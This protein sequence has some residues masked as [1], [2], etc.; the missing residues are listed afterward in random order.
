MGETILVM[1]KIMPYQKLEEEIKNQAAFACSLRYEDISEKVRMRARYVLL[2][3]VGCILKGL[4]GQT[5]S[6]SFDDA[7]M[8]TSAAMLSTELYEGNRF[9]CGHPACHIVPMM[10]EYLRRHD[11]SERKVL[12]AFVAAYEIAARWGSAV[13]FERTIL[14]HGTVM[15]AGAAV[16][17]ALLE[18]DDESTVTQSILLANSL[19]MLSVW[20]TVYDGSR[21]HDAYPGLAALNGIRAVKMARQG[22]YST[23]RIIL[24]VYENKMRA[25]AC[26]DNLDKG[27]LSEDAGNGKTDYLLLK[28]YFKLFTGCR[29]IH[30]FADVVQEE[31]EHGLT[32][33]EIS[34]IE[35]YTY[36]KAA[37]LNECNIPND[38]SAKFSMSISIAAQ[39]VRG[40]LGVDEIHD[41]MLDPKIMDLSG[42]IKLFHDGHYDECLPDL[43]GG[44]IRIIKKN[45]SEI[46]RE[47]LHARGDFDYPGETFETDVKKKFSRNVVR[48]LN[49]SQ[50]M[51]EEKNI[52]KMGEEEK[53][54][55][56]ET[57]HFCLEGTA[58]RKKEKMCLKTG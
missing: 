38:L 17:F 41:C 5:V 35:V 52:L 46:V 44:R 42:R 47:T 34:S 53:K 16:A 25:T 21:L 27:L 55:A 30:P 40:N 18:N 51:I 26:F 9:A 4:N 48:Y 7:V 19:P 45:G 29:F 28:N 54:I 39:L 31:M 50:T 32:E 22:Y 36:E 14:G 13:R 57:F 49:R 6:S 58:E 15:T 12:T 2:D 56:Q 20:Q 8:E 23:G 24:D 33:D 43:R 10:L 37:Q 11:V 1:K 3:S